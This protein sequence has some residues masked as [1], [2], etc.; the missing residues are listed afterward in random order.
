MGLFNKAAEESIENEEDKIMPVFHKLMAKHLVE[1]EKGD[2]TLV[3]TIIQQVCGLHFSNPD[4]TDKGR[5][6]F[7]GTGC[8]QQKSPILRWFNRCHL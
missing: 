2:I 6:E 8:A 1:D 5:S 4:D 7:E 3:G